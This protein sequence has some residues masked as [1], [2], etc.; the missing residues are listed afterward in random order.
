MRQGRSAHRGH[1]RRAVGGQD[2]GHQAEGVGEVLLVGDDGQQG[3]LGQQAVADL[4]A[5]GSPHEPGLPRG[6]GREVVVVHVPLVVVGGDGVEQLVH[7]G[8][9]QGGHVEHL[10]L[11]PLEQGRAVGRREQVHLGRQR[12]DL[13]GGPTVDAEALLH[14]ALAHQLLGQATHGRLDL[15]ARGRGTRRPAVSMMKAVAASRAALRSALATILLAS[16]M[17][18]D[19]DGLDPLEHVVPVVGER[20]VLD[21]LDRAAGGHVGVH[22]LALE[23]DRLADPRLGRFEPVGQDLLGDLGR[24]L[25]VVL[26]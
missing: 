25:V 19:A 17:A 9:A 22:Q 24:T 8:H 20:R 21:G 23:H 14:D 6:E 16:A 5:L 15:A 10:G 3:P 2:V 26:E 18:S 1:R 4:P 13:G 12:A 11:A 7:A